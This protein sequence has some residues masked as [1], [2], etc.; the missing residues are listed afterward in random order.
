MIASQT[1]HPYNQLL[2]QI[3]TN[4][5]TPQDIVVRHNVLL[6]EGF[7]FPHVTM[8]EEGELTPKKPAEMPGVL[9]AVGLYS[10]EKEDWNEEQKHCLPDGIR[11]QYLPFLILEY[12]DD[13]ISSDY[14]E[15]S[16]FAGML[17]KS[18]YFHLLY[19]PDLDEENGEEEDEDLDLNLPRLDRNI[20][21]VP[22]CLP[23]WQ[24]KYSLVEQTPGVWKMKS[25]PFQK[26]LHVLSLDRLPQT[27]WNASLH[28]LSLDSEVRE[29]AWKHLGARGISRQKLP[30]LT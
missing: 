28:I 22:Q 2:G 9:G 25:G 18:H 24:E 13:Q 8:G 11:E 23:E 7:Y 29:Q 15:E 19:N 5:L 3:F 10:V 4:L 27:P 14:Y 26:L 6:Q 17:I 16:V 12:S 1:L 30:P 20:S 21:I